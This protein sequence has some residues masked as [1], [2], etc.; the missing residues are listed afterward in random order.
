MFSVGKMGCSRR[1]GHRQNRVSPAEWVGHRFSGQ[2]IGHPSAVHN[3]AV[4]VGAGRQGCFL[5]PLA[6]A[7][8]MERLG[9]GPPLIEG[10]RDANGGGR[11]IS[12]FKADGLQLQSGAGDVVV[13]VIVFHR[14]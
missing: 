13:I 3:E 1:A 14:G 7:G 10:S 9:F 5:P 12:E 6:D 4:F 8:G 2:R 11:G